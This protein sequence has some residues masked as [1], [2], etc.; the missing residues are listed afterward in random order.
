MGD[1]QRLTYSE[2]LLDHFRNPRGVGSLDPHDGRGTIG[3]PD[4]GDFLEVTLRLSEDS[5]TISEIAFR[6]QGCPAAIA[7]SSAMIELVRG[8]SV[9]EALQLTKEQI[10]EH[11][12]GVPERKVHCSLLAI[13]GLQRALNHAFLRRMFTRSGIVSSP[14]ELDEKLVAGELDSYFHSCDGSCSSKAE[15]NHPEAPSCSERARNER[16]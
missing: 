2:K 14:E 1:Q 8:R 3:D 7:T 5:Q 15:G 11:L 4:C 10:I 9:D 13:D 12:G 16:E 6:V